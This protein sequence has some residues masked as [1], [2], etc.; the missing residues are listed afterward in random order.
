MPGTGYLLLMIRGRGARFRKRIIYCCDLTAL[1]L[2]STVRESAE[3]IALFSVHL[4]RRQYMLG[5]LIIH[6]RVARVWKSC[7]TAWAASTG[8]AWEQLRFSVCAALAL[9]SVVSE[10]QRRQ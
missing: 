1:A 4:A 8:F 7:I 3:T 9:L 6:G 2:L 5:L 10:P